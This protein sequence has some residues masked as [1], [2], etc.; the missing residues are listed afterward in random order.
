MFQGIKRTTLKTILKCTLKAFLGIVDDV[1]NIVSGDPYLFLRAENQLHQNLH[2]T[3]E[4]P[5]NQGNLA[6]FDLKVYVDSLKRITR[7]WYQKPTDTG[8][9]L[10]FRS[11]AL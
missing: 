1:G 9:K 6:F 2:F 3:L 11:S 4:K 5:D 10:N 8:T 7:G